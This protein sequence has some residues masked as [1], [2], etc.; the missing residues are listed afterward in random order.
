MARMIPHWN[1][2]SGTTTRNRDSSYQQ[3]IRVHI[4]LSWPVPE[5]WRGGDT[6]QPLTHSF[7]TGSWLTRAMTHI[8][9]SPQAWDD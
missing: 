7:R 2:Y 8:N 1:N 4:G 9:N 6:T 3:V 5:F